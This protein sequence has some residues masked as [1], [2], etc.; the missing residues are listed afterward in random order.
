MALKTLLPH[1]CLVLRLQQRNVDG[2]P[3]Y[4]WLPVATDEP[5]RVDLAFRR[6]VD[7]RW[8]AE[9]GRPADRSGVAFF[10]PS[11]PVRP[12]DR[13][14]LTRGGI[15]GTFKVMGALDEVT[16]RKGDLHHIEVGVEEVAQ[17]LV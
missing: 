8:S 6:S 7:P 3:A 16:G 13:I 1:R 10:P 9:A 5:C 12:G 2:A 17:A 11:A 14:R 15:S 4:D